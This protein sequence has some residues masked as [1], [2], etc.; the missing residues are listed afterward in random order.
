MEVPTAQEKSEKIFS[1]QPKACQNK[2]ADLN[3]TVSANPL[4]MIAFFKQCQVTDKAAGVLEKIT[5][6]KKQ[7]KEKST[8]DVPT[9][10]SHESSYKQQH[11]H[12]YCNYHRSNQRDRDD[13]QPDYCNWDN[14][15]HDRGCRDNKDARNNKSYNKKDDYK[16]DYFKKKSNKAMHN[17]QSSLSSA[18][19]LSG[20]RS[21][22][23]SRSPSHSCS[24][25]CSCSSSRSYENH[26][27]EQHDCKPSA[28]P[29]RGCLYSKDNDDGH[30]HHPDKSDSIFATFSA[31]KTKRGNH[32]QK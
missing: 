32:T 7:P 21:Q 24:C 9:T 20:R 10:R 28:A 11:C 31:P 23:C 30:Y 8:A 4:R 2:F 25:S 26:H 15:C 1:A 3:K 13:R 29:K 17:D 12:E 6:D 22:S 16:R 19:N 14:Q 18:G 5:K 27:V